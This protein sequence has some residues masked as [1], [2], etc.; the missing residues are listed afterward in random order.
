[1]YVATM[2]KRSDRSPP[3]SPDSGT[4]ERGT[5]DGNRLREALEPRDRGDPAISSATVGSQVA[6]GQFPS[7]QTTM[8]QATSDQATNGPTKPLP[9][10]N[11]AS[12]PRI[13]PRL[14]PT[15][16]PWRTITD[17]PRV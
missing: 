2:K 7:G 9:A 14:P 11:R 16:P 15:P 10:A 13:E 8:D 5:L 17:P 6:S 12:E 3:S 4:I 1:M